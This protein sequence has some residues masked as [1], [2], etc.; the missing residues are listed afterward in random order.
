MFLIPLVKHDSYTNGG[1]ILH[2]TLLYIRYIII[3]FGSHSHLVI[4]MI[5]S[6]FNL[7]DFFFFFVYRV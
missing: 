7:I 5:I 4:L 6:F 2:V 3:T 1:I